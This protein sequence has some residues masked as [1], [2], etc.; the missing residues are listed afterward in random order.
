[1]DDG[2]RN[3]VPDGIAGSGTT[4]KMARNLNRRYIGCDISSEYVELARKRLRDTD[5]FQDRQITPE[6]RQRSLFS[7]VTI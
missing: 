2:R 7:G 5:P 6:L 1:M 3:R 4:L